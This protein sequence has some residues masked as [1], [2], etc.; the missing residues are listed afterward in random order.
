[1][2]FHQYVLVRIAVTVFVM[3]GVVTLAFVVSHLIPVDPIRAVVG[4]RATAEQIEMERARWGLDKPLIVQYVVFWQ[5]LLQGKLGRS[6]WSS[7]PV[8]IELAERFPAT[9]ELTLASAVF[10]IGLG[11]PLGVIAATR[12]NQWADQLVRGVTIFGLSIPDFWLG[13]IL[14]YIFYQQF[15]FG[16]LGRLSTGVS[17]PTHITGMFVLD[18]LLTGNWT[19]LVDSASHLVLPAFTLSLFFLAVITR[20]TRSSMLEVLNKPYIAV[21]RV[22]GLKERTVIYKHALR[23]ALI[24]TVTTIGFS[25]GLIL[26]GAVVVETVFTWP[27]L[28]YLTYQAVLKM[29]IPFIMGLSLLTAFIYS[30]ANLLVDIAY[31]FLDPRIRY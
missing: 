5:Q 14:L 11:I 19:S 2:K 7:R 8:E 17:P 1:M 16:G 25:I 28:G 21:A 12:R 30:I 23:N 20:M 3:I 13:L 10:A 24:P 27:G 26:G 29:D 6:I 31:G 15:S 9:A 22:K 4:P 18:S